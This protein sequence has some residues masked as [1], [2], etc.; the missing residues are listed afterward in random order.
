[1][2]DVPALVLAD[3]SHVATPVE[4]AVRTVARFPRG[5]LLVTRLVPPSDC[6]QLAVKR[7]MRGQRV[8]DRC[9]R[10]APLVQPPPPAPMSL[11]DVQLP[12]LGER[13][14]RGRL[15]QAFAL[16]FG[17]LVD[18]FYA[19][20][21][22]KPDSFF[23]NRRLRGGGL[24]GGGYVIGESIARL[25]RYEF[26]PGVRLSGRWNE[27]AEVMRI[28]IDGPGRLDGRIIVSG[29]GAALSLRVRG[30][31][32]GRDVSAIVIVPSH[33]AAVIEESISG[34]AG[35]AA[36]LPLRPS[37]GRPSSSPLSWP[38]WSPPRRRMRR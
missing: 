8:Q 15:V 1:M 28:R 27:S 38:R 23:S 20:F 25:H 17:D 4:A 31:I 2:P 30:R 10:S 24:R 11:R 7:F 19:G 12:A 5:R 9:A 36:A 21:F 6:A 32:A 35:A 34:S 18:D 22:S 37:G 3:S 26:V 29:T 16:T 13:G 14:R 33:L